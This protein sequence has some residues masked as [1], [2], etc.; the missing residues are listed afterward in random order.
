MFKKSTSNPKLNVAAES[1]WSAP[2]S[3]SSEILNVF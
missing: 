2:A 3:L 1:F